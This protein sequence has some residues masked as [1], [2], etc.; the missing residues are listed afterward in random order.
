MQIRATAQIPATVTITT[1]ANTVAAVSPY[2][3]ETNDEPVLISGYINLLIGTAGVLATIQVYSGATTSGTAIGVAAEETVVATDRYSIPFYAIDA[4]VFPL[5][6][7]YCVAVTIGSA[8]GNSTIEDAVI[9]VE[10][11]NIQ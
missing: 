10:T 3:A 1:T 5:G 2:I 6:N 8:S 11:A 7:Q 4:S 9:K